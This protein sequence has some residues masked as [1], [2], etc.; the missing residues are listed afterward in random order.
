MEIFTNLDKSRPCEF[1]FTYLC[2]VKKKRLFHS[3]I[4]LD[5]GKKCYVQRVT[6]H[7]PS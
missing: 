7:Q 2:S 6:T 5:Y 4:R 3:K 1:H